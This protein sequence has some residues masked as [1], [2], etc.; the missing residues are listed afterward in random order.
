[1]TIDIEDNVSRCNKYFTLTWLILDVLQLYVF[2]ASV[3]IYYLLN[4]NN[5]PNDKPDPKPYGFIN[6]AVRGAYLAFVILH[7]VV[8]FLP[9]LIVAISRQN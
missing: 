8:T 6:D 9:A 1:M 2:Y 5:I 4:K 7:M 3:A